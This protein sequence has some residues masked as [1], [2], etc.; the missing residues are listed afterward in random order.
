VGEERG[1]ARCGDDCRC[2]DALSPS[3]KR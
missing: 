3:A 2:G 1:C